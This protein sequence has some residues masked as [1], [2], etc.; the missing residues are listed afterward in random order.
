MG[1]AFWLN[2]LG[3]SPDWYK[4]TILAFLVIN[5]ILFVIPQ[6]HVAVLG[7]L[8]VIQFIFTLAMALKCYP[9]LPGGL[10]ALEA[11]VLGLATPESI[12]KEVQ[13]N[14]AVILLLMFMVAGIY[15]MKNLLLYVFSELLISV[16]SKII[17]SFLFSFVAAFLSAF[18]DALTVTAV[19]IAVAIG[20]YA[21]YTSVAAGLSEVPESVHD[22]PEPSEEYQNDL[23]QFRGFLRNLVMHGA[24]GTALGGVMTLV[25]EPQNI[26]IAEKL[27]WKFMQFVYEMAPV[28]VPVLITGLITCLL[29]EATKTFGYGQ[30]LPDSVRE[31]LHKEHARE[32]AHQTP[33]QKAALIVQ[34]VVVVILIIALATHAAEVGIIGLTIIVLQTAL[35][36]ET[37]EHHIGKAFQEALPFT[38]LLVVFF[39]IIAVIHTLHLFTPISD[40]VLSLPPEVQPGL[41]YIA[42]GLLSVISDNVFVAT[43]YIGDVADAFHSGQITR[44]QFDALGIAINT[45]TN[46]PSILTPNGQAAFLFLLTSS[47]AP[48][49]ALS[50]GR[51]VV[52]AFPY[53]VT[54]GTVGFIC[55]NWLLI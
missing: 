45:G 50:Y 44:E 22:I 14:L 42:N 4:Y 9:L 49:I 15:F 30:T 10:L 17:L 33:R 41:Y 24:V 2:F 48:L 37:E 36:G 27:D 1:H 51:M 32:M 29:L 55:A 11:I 16:R 40:W 3:S 43:V 35:N 52:M 7:W 8:L 6:V 12:Y 28:T 46:I 38:A 25:G 53:F 19:I 5:P 21:I 34:A 23:N 20:F 39:A 31:I 26:I 54:M 18:L 13:T 47:L